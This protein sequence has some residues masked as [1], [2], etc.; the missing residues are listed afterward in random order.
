MPTTTYTEINIFPNEKS[1]K[2]FNNINELKENNYHEVPI[3]DIEELFKSHRGINHFKWTNNTLLPAAEVSCTDTVDLKGFDSGYHDTFIKL[4]PLNLKIDTSKLAICHINDQIGYGVVATDIIPKGRWLLFNG[5][6]HKLNDEGLYAHFENNVYI[7]FVK[8]PLTNQKYLVDSKNCGGFSSLV[9]ASAHKDFLTNMKQADPDNADNIGLE[10]LAPCKVLLNGVTQL[11]IVTTRD[12]QPNELLFGEYEKSYFMQFSGP[13]IVLN[14][15]GS[16]ASSKII[17]LVNAKLKEYVLNRNVAIFG[18]SS[19]KLSLLLEEIG[20]KQ[21]RHKDTEAPRVF[22]DEEI[23]IVYPD[24]Y[25]DLIK[26]AKVLLEESS[27]NFAKEILS[28]A[29]ILNDKFNL[30]FDQKA[31]ISSQLDELFSR[32][33]YPK[34]AS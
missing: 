34:F 14:K 27:T 15:D 28:F 26:L 7:S 9:L 33:D 4:D 12:I 18:L 8:N 29:Q 31:I 2:V 5:E 23:F 22:K 6:T 32:V 3:S 30:A 21:V 1:I 11:A 17:E 20:Q 24:V 10:N 19:L 13:F 16:S 25:S